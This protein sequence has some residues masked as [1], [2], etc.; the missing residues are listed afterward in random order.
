[1]E[2]DVEHSHPSSAEVKNQWSYTSIPSLCLHEVD[3]DNSTFTIF[4]R[5][6]NYL[7]IFLHY[8]SFIYLAVGLA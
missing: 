1:L 2:H 4:S 7:C 8:S 3:M 5:F 6:L